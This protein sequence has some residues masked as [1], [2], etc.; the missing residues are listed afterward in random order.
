MPLPMMPRPMN[1]MVFMAMRIGFGAMESAIR[2]KPR[3][4]S[5]LNTGNG[6]RPTLYFFGESE[7][8]GDGGRRRLPRRRKMLIA[9]GEEAT[10]EDGASVRKQEGC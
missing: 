10:G 8:G 1:A 7:G 5:P 9:D 2:K 6:S 3:F 4:E